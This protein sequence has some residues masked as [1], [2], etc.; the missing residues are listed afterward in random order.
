MIENVAGQLVQIRIFQ[1]VC[2]GR[3]ESDWAEFD[4]LNRDAH[5]RAKEVIMG[6]K[7]TSNHSISAK[8]HGQKNTYLN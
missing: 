8:R 5:I 3:P 7:V 4:F 2:K 6:L 1:R